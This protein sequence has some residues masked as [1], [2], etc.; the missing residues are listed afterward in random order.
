MS[1]TSVE[2]LSQLTSAMVAAYGD[3][4]NVVGNEIGFKNALT[5]QADGVKFTV[6]QADDFAT[7]YTLKNHLP[8][9]ELNGFSATV[10][11]DKTTGKHV[12][13][14]RGTEVNSIGQG[15]LDLI[16]QDGL[17]IAGNGFANTQAVEMMRYYRRLTTAGGQAVQYTEQQKWLMFAI[18]NSLLVPLA[19]M[20]PVLTT[21]L[22]GAYLLFKQGLA[23]DTGITLPAGSLG[24]SVLSPTETVNVTGHSL[25]G[26]LA[27]LFARIFPAN[28][29]EVV[30][31]NAPGLFYQ[32]DR[33]LTAFGFPPPNS[34]QI[35][36][37]EA[38][39]NADL[40]LGSTYM[41]S[42]LA[43]GPNQITYS[44]T[45]TG[46]DLSFGNDH[47]RARAVV[48]ID[49]AAIDVLTGGMLADRLHGGAENGV[50]E[51]NAING[52][53]KSDAPAHH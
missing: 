11:L 1:I 43:L 51:S 2:S 29:D 33:A 23:A 52:R 6:T 7:R 44:D 16:A 5:R 19:A 45:E 39:G 25:G 34:N 32:G 22:A 13:A 15:I 53:A 4:R 10:F 38:D 28:V 9:V 24:L 27:M 18:S 41:T 31:L 50:T 46:F 26:H 12:I 35:T 42:A 48:R 8:N 3:L 21:A 37:I 30:T 14:M 40:E 17:S 47:T 36:R 20:V 49:V